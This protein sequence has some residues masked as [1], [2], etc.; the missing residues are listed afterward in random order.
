MRDERLEAIR[1]QLLQVREDLLSEL[2]QKNAEAAALVDEGVADPGDQGLLDRL[3][4]VLH[5]LGDSRREEILRADEA[6]MRLEQGN[7]GQCLQCGEA[8]PLERLELRPHTRFCVACKEAL[9]REEK[10]KAGPGQGTL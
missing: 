8:I 3:K 10:L 9:E 7:Y 6:L 2:R 5:L 4:E 1:R